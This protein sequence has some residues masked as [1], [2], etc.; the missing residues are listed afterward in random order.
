M[1]STLELKRTIDLC[2]RALDAQAATFVQHA[3]S[4][5]ASSSEEPLEG[6]RADGILAFLRSGS[7]RLVIGELIGEGG[8]GTVNAATQV[9]LGRVVAVKRVRPET[10]TPKYERALVAEALIAGALEH[11]NVVPLYAME[12]DDHGSPM[13]IMKRVD[14]VPWSRLLHDAD[15]VHARGATEPLV[16]HLKVLSDVCNAVAFAHSRYVIHRDLKPDNVLIGHFGE[17]YLADW[18]IAGA[19]GTPTRVSGT[20]AYMAPEMLLCEE[21]SPRTDVYLLGA[22]LFEI[23]TGRAP[24]Q[25]ASVEALVASILVSVP[26]IP[27]Y[28]PTELA[29][30][31]RACLARDPNERPESARVVQERIA[32]FLDHRGSTALATQA[33]LLRAHIKVA[34][35][36][37]ETTSIEKSFTECRFA[38]REALRTWPANAHAKAGLRELLLMMMDFAIAEGD[39]AGARRLVAELDEPSAAALA[40]I[41]DLERREHAVAERMERLS[42]LEREHDPRVG[43]RARLTVGVVIGLLWTMLPL[44]GWWVGIRF[45]NLETLV[46]LP[47][48]LLALGALALTG[49]LADWHASELNR[50]LGLTFGFVLLVEAVAVSVLYMLHVPGH[51]V[52]RGL[53]FYWFVAIGIAGA[54]V[55]PRLFP[56]AFAYLLGSVIV[57]QWPAGRYVCATLVNLFFTISIAL[58]WLRSPERPDAPREQ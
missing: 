5:I 49:Q 33:D 36:Q 45:G 30:L 13:L 19:P 40:A 52:T 14:G 23:L 9:A 16:F 51:F 2:V 56:A 37:S 29:G 24:H 38:Y 10:N 4:T 53:F 44:V 41:A 8:M 32:Q 22:V 39:L 54:S 1:T 55:E 25:G 28:V 47:V 3:R 6:Q 21:L 46:T 26:E 34:I 12:L 43:R 48:T 57:W 18:G 58:V 11:P 31:V 42:K 27:S 20:P 15:A 17:V 50:R 35:A 7:E